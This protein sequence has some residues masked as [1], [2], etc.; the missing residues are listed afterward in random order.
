M[1]FIP[2]YSDKKAEHV[3]RGDWSP[4]SLFL[5]VRIAFAQ[6][7][8]S[9]KDGNSCLTYEPGDESPRY[10]DDARSAT[11]YTPHLLPTPNSLSFIRT[12]HSKTVQGRE[13]G[14]SFGFV[15]SVL[16][17]VF[18]NMYD[19]NDNNNKASQYR[20][21]KKNN[22]NKTVIAHL[23]RLLAEWRKHTFWCCWKCFKNAKTLQSDWQNIKQ[24]I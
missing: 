23:T 3:L 18:Q 20:N 14:G 8:L 13:E 6:S 7:A 24:L 16:N 5:K 4:G 17:T 1:K 12:V 19:N 22:N 2:K 10:A 21:S 9:K 15:Y 11:R